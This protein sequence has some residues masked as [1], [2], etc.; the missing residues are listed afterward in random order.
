MRFFTVLVPITLLLQITNDL[1]PTTS[2]LESVLRTIHNAIAA[3]YYD[4]NVA[5]AW[6]RNEK[7]HKESILRAK[8]KQ[9]AVNKIRQALSELHNS[10]IFFYTRDEWN[11]R[12]NVL[13]FLYEK[14]EGRVFVRTP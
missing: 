9:E 12:E 6:N 8:S 5:R 2:P 7:R 3:E 11:L 4:P 13:P 1:R 10:H 14:R